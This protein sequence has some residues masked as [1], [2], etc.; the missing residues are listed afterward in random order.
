[1]S[2]KPRV[3]HTARLENAVVCPC[4]GKMHEAGGRYCC[5]NDV[6]PY[7]GKVYVAVVMKAT[8]MYEVEQSNP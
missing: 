1:M 6:C 2:G 7:F 4:G 8:L 3:S 5:L